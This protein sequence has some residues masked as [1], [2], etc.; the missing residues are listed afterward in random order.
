MD[1]ISVKDFIA[2]PMQ[3]V[4]RSTT[5]VVGVQR[6]DDKICAMVISPDLYEV[7]TLYKAEYERIK[8]YCRTPTF[9]NALPPDF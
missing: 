7:L 6:D 3:A 9:L 5:A 4:L 8:P 2:A 1:T